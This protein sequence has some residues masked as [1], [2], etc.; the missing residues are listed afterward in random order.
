MKLLFVLFT[1]F[2]A[3]AAATERAVSPAE[4]ERLVTGKTF[5]YANGASI[6][7]AETYL[8]NRQVRWSFLDGECTDGTW[9]VAG[10]QI[11]FVYDDIPT[12]QCWQFYMV[13]GTLTARYQDDPLG[14]E[15]YQ[16]HQRAPLYCETPYLGS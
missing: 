1:L 12:P 14:T 7:G 8:E 6:Y 16:T 3:L 10:D 2:P 13:D 15:L 9:Y 4:F 5:S 11:C